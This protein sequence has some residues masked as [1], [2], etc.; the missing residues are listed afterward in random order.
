[1]CETEQQLDGKPIL[2]SASAWYWGAAHKHKQG[3]SHLGR[4]EGGRALQPS[5]VLWPSKAAGFI[6]DN[7]NVGGVAATP[8]GDWCA[9][10]V[11]A[12][13]SLSNLCS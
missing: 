8:A 2:T 1:M 11:S 13:N 3:G 5:S 6:V 12:V 9:E 7:D 10:A 4:D